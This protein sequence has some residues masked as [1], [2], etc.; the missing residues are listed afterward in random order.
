MRT[1]APILNHPDAA[2]MITGKPFIVSILSGK[3][4][5]GKSTVALNLACA[6]G[7]SE[8]RT[9]LIDLDWS[10]GSLHILANVAPEFSVNDVIREKAFVKDVAIPLTANVSLLASAS[11]TGDSAA[12]EPIELARFM[13]TARETLS[14]Y[15]VI[16][17]DTP[18]ELSESLGV[19]AHTS[20]LPILV[21]NPEITAITACYGMYKFLVTL[22]KTFTGATLLN[23]ASSVSE[24]N[25]IAQRFETMTSRFLGRTPINIG[26]VPLDLL[27]KNSVARQTPVV[28]R[29]PSAKSSV[30]FNVIAG[31]IINL[32]FKNHTSPRLNEIE[33][34]NSNYE[35]LQADIK[36]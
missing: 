21:L 9:L 35:T 32:L 8:L 18:C 3:G 26:S 25:D 29:H 31:R 19:I 33:T 12:P 16:V 24:A 10:L 28:V 13:E 27:I 5:V 23:C 2:D 7:H 30:Q 14:G 4:G 17:I 36:G 22:N 11:A 34:R 1:S 15:K 6:L 20:D